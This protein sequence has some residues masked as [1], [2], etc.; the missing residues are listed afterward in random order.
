MGFLLGSVL[1][2]FLISLLLGHLWLLA[3]RVTKNLAEHPDLAYFGAI[4]LSVAPLLLPTMQEM[5]YLIGASLAALF[6]LFRWL[7]TE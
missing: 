5:M 1:G 6:F 3:F 2:G 7:H 4:F